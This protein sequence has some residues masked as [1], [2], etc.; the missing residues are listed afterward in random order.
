MN[1]KYPNHRLF[2]AERVLNR[3]LFR[4]CVKWAYESGDGGSVNCSG[5]LLLVAHTVGKERERG[6]S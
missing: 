2:K 5:V 4:G 1:H 3:L 6:E